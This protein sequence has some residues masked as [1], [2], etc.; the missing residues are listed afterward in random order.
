MSPA[1]SETTSFVDW[2]HR[3]AIIGV[4]GA[5]AMLKPNTAWVRVSAA[6]VGNSAGILDEKEWRERFE[7]DFG[8]LDL[9]LDL[10][11]TPSNVPWHWRDSK[12]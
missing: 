5:Y 12:K 2:D 1:E 11:D 3:P 8:K 9:P 4:G 6:D 7:G 10:A